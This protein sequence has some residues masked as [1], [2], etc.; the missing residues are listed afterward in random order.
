MKLMWMLFSVAIVAAVNCQPVPRF[1][2]DNGVLPNNSYILYSN[3]TTGDRALKCVTD[4][5]D[6]CTDPDVGNW[7][8]ETGRAVQQRA[9]GANCLYVTRGQREV[10]LNR[11]ST[12][13]PEFGLWRCDIPDSSGVIQSMYIYIVNDSSGELP[14][15]GTI[16]MTMI[17]YIANS[18]EFSQTFTNLLILI[19]LIFTI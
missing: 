2:H 10:S 9:N 19:I 4:R 17:C 1:E 5:V 13:Y 11:N 6:C 15:Y 18:G 8:Y 7:T 3:I 14:L 12:C 16:M